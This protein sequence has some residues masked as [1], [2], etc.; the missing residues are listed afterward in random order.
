MR[1][2]YLRYERQV[3]FLIIGG[4]NTAI[5]LA[6]FPILYYGLR[7]YT[8]HY[9]SILVV[10][11]II[12][13][14]SAFFTNKFF[15]FKT[16]GNYVAEF[17]RFITF[18]SGYFVINLIAMP[19]FVEVLHIHPVITQGIISIGIIV[20]SYFWHSRITFVDQAEKSDNAK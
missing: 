9:M 7:A 2:L 17:L 11:Q 5:G 10:S 14:T 4:I 1:K 20:S 18:Y 15:V 8:L 19:I 12:C 6:A 3:N 13:V 16:Q